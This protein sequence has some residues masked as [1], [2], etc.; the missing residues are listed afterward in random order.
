MSTPF[1]E[2]DP[3][4]L[5]AGLLGRP[6]PTVTPGLAQDLLQG[7]PFAPP[8]MADGRRGVTG[9]WLS[10]LARDPSPTPA[11]PAVADAAPVQAAPNPVTDAGGS[12]PNLPSQAASAQPYDVDKAVQYLD[13]HA[14]PY[15]TQTKNGHCGTAV[16][17]AIGAGGIDLTPTPYAKDY[18]SSLSSAGYTKLDGE[19]LKNY[20]PEAGDVMIYPGFITAEGKD[21]S[22]GHAQMFDGKQWVSD[23]KQHGENLGVSP[24]SDFHDQP[25]SVYR[26]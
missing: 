11:P 1:D 10:G 8:G 7:F 6:Y 13:E 2:D 23:F 15:Y 9:P 19:N 4:G 17:E 12:N 5:A 24:G 14:T 25:F 21:H 26:H 3:Q 18:G 22:A 20:T 16:R